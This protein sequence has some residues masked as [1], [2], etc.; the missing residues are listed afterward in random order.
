MK[1][2]SA[3]LTLILSA[4]LSGVAAAQKPAP[5]PPAPPDPPDAEDFALER[6]ASAA[7]DVSVTL[8]LATGNVSV[9]GW[10]RNEVRARSVESGKLVMQVAG[11]Q[12]A[13]RIEVLASRDEDHEIVSGDCGVTDA[14]EL[15]VPRGASVQLTVHEGNVE[16]EGVA[17]VRVQELSGDVELRGVSRSA[18]VT[19]MSGDITLS[20]SKGRAR[21]HAV[22]GSVEA[23]NVGP[24]SSG[25]ALEASTTSGDVTLEDVRHARVSGVTISGNVRA[26]GAL[27]RGGSY[28]YKTTSGNVTL[29]LPADSSFRLNARVVLDGSIVTDFPVKTA[30]AAPVSPTSP[31]DPPTTSMG[32]RAPRRPP[33]PQST[34]LVGT[35]GTGDA[36]LNLTSFS[37][38]L[39]LKRQ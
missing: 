27:V 37:G 8:C 30:G 13:K 22:S 32:P 4:A 20:D 23:L 2:S 3:I 25:D 17:E 28:D 29:A 35:V 24:T 15:A 36:S 14:I 34:R 10:D 19:T 16:V 18:E 38:T 31:P 1:F 12:P 9:R 26:S 11:D 6:R 21:L 7:P 33:G 39:H 5:A